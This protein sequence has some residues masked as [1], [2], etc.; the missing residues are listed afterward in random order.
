MKKVFI[1]ALILFS[2]SFIS[3]DCRLFMMA[4]YGNETLS[5]TY[6]NLALEAFLDE[7]Q[8]QGYN[9]NH[10]YN[11]PDG[12]GLGYYLP[13]DT[14]IT[15]MYRSA[16]PAFANEYYDTVQN[17]IQEAGAHLVVGH[18]RRQTTG[19]VGVPD[20]NPFIWS[21]NGIDYCFAHNGTLDPPG[22]QPPSNNSDDLYD[23]L[24]Y[25]FNVL[26]TD[27]DSEI[28]FRWLMQNMDENDWNLLDGLHAAIQGLSVLE[29]DW[30]MNFVLSDGV[31][32]YAYRNAIDDEHELCFGWHTEMP[33]YPVVNKFRV[34][35]STLP[36]TPSIGSTEM[37][38]DALLYYPANGRTTL[39][40]NFS[41]AQP[42]Y[43]R[44][45]V[46]GWNWESLPTIPSI[47]GSSNAEALLYDLTDNGITQVLAYNNQSMTYSTQ[48]VWSHNPA[49]F[50]NLNWNELYKIALG[51][52]IYWFQD[53]ATYKGYEVTGYIRDSDA[54]TLTNIEA[55]EEYW[56][57]YSLLPTQNMDDA[58]GDE[59]EN[60]YS[61]KSKDWTY[62]DL[63]YPEGGSRGIDPSPVPSMQM[64]ALEFGKG[65]IVKFK[66]DIDSFTWN[67]ERVPGTVEIP[68]ES[69]SESFSYTEL[70]DYE[71]IDIMEIEGVENIQEIGVFEDDV[72][73]GAV[74]TNELPVQIRAYTTGSG[75]ELTFQ[76]VEGSRSLPEKKS[77]S[78]YNFDRQQFE[79]KNL[80]SGQQAYSMIKLGKD[81][82]EVTVSS[83]NVSNLS[84]FP[85]PFNPTTTLYFSLSSEANILLNVYNLKGQLVRSL[86]SGQYTSGS[87]SVAW[88]GKDDENKPVCSGLYLYKL[89]TNDQ[90]ISKK[91][92]ILK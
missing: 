28:Y 35:M 84:N 42:Q 32:M 58:F 38:N 23:M 47:S 36:N 90:V 2:V 3:A 92:L 41:N 40:K 76:V 55:Y 83:P 18:V 73:V 62:M 60:V 8:D 89:I 88:D 7:L 64:R 13:D 12:W 25:P 79:I 46:S 57:S 86:T 81:N 33:T 11:N 6:N 56:I 68:E 70:A 77:Y 34:V 17:V 21:E 72:C 65:Y 10:P 24:Y 16:D 15:A 78:V 61:V 69:K 9:G 44:S 54:P 22:L 1:I 66:E 85:N 53:A 80:R 74:V 91:M 14:E 30:N 45:M 31:D 87:H 27:V 39:L 75:E 50:I 52:S 26:Q 71:A 67:Y 37:P 43:K 59:W 4:G 51:N 48:G 82:Y 20:P 5:E 19:T 29:D 49:S 63:S